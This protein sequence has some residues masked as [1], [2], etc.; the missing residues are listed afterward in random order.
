[1]IYEWVGQTSQ[2][3]EKRQYLIGQDNIWGVAK[4]PV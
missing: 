2:H 4:R 1:M 3:H